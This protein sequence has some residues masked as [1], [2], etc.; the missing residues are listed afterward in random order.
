MDNTELLD[1]INNLNSAVQSMGGNASVTNDILLQMAKQQGVNVNNI[2][3]NLNSFGKNVNEASGAAQSLKKANDEYKKSM[4]LLSK[5]ATSAAAGLGQ[6]SS[7]LLDSTRNFSKYNTALSS[8]GDSAKSLGESLGGLGPVIGN[9][10]KGMTMVGAAALKQADNVN[11]AYDDLAKVGGA[12]GLT[13]KEIMNMGLQAGLMSKDLGKFT[14]AIKSNSTAIAGLG[15]S[16]ADGMKVFGQMTAV[17][18]QTVAQYSKLG[19][20]Q[21]ELLKTQSDYVALQMASGR[22]LKG[23]IQ[24]KQKLQKASLEY[25]DNLLTLSQLTGEDVESIKKKQQEAMSALNWQISQRQLENKAVALEKTGSEEGRAAAKKIREEMENR[26]KGMQSVAAIGSKGLSEAVREMQTTGTSTSKGAQAMIRLGLGPAIEEYKKTVKEGGDATKAAA[27][28]QN[29]YNEAQNKAVDTIGGAASVNKDVAEAFDLTAENMKRGTEQYGK[30]LVDQA[31]K[32][33]KNIQD[34][35][36]TTD[37]ALKSRAALTELEMKAGKFFEDFL[38]KVNPL[39]GGSVTAFVALS[40]AVGY[41]TLQL[42]KMSAS[43]A[44]QAMG[45]KGAVPTGGGGGG[46]GKGVGSKIGGAIKGGA[47]GAILGVAGSV[48]KDSGYDK[49]GA[50]LDIAS[51]AATGAAIGSVIPGVGTVVGGALGAAYGLYQN[52]DALLGGGG[53]TGGMSESETKEMIKRHEGVRTRPYQDSKGLWTVGVGHLIGDGKT[54]P[55]GWNREFSMDE[56]NKMFEE[57]F[58]KHKSAAE[59][60]NGFNKLNGDGKAALTDMTFNMGPSWIKNWPTLEKQIGAGDMKGAASNIAGSAYAKQVGKRSQEIISLLEKGGI[61]ARDG[62]DF[63][64]P[65]SGYLVALHGR[66]RVIPE[67]RSGMLVGKSNLSVNKEPLPSQF[68]GSMAA[69]GDGMQ[70]ELMAKMIGSL[71]SKFDQLIS[72]AEQSNNTQDKILRYSKA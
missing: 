55:P 43:L 45:G 67:Y 24:D 10:I 8:F 63:D 7:A 61:S 60:I 21:E 58:A 19:V 64:G 3:T 5:S 6:F 70:M 9:V 50:G 51:S 62:G 31:D 27:K 11:K 52:K 15:G 28:L 66:E 57:D 33:K 41:A 30:D 56:V 49:V 39:M 29:A 65:E 18:T 71:E 69:N 32:S 40:A 13:T 22:S 48:A 72:V 20:S 14:S 46:G 38:A 12:G 53:A 42:T 4:D 36:E 23:E 34:Q 54:L 2:N 47:A 68:T 26:A 44:A 17:G 16:A 59:Q 35:K 37:P 1:A 25:Q